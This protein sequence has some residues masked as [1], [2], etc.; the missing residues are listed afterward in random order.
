L[1]VSKGRVAARGHGNTSEPAGTMGDCLFFRS[2]G[3]A[4]GVVMLAPGKAAGPTDGQA[5]R[6]YKD[7]KRAA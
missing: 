7:R 2:V 5:F 3:T 6:L 4:H 1:A